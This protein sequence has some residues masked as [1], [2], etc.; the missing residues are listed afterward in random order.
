MRTNLR[1]IPR[2]LPGVHRKNWRRHPFEEA[3]VTDKTKYEKHHAPLLINITGS[4][5][6]A[7]APTIAVIIC[8]GSD[9]AAPAFNCGQYLCRQ[10][11]VE[12]RSRYGRL[13]PRRE[14]DAPERP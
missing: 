9:V 6:S 14:L 7:S 8:D 3:P 13:E 12:D 5:F 4:A 10:R 11:H 2:P 1:P